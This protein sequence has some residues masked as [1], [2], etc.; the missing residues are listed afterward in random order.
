MTSNLYS[1]EKAIA[2]SHDYDKDIWDMVHDGK[3]VKA[4]YEALSQRELH[5]D[6]DEFEPLYD[7]TEGI[8]GY[9][10]WRSS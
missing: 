3:H 4:I 6:A 9:V 5:S 7:K 10:V 1:V 2:G 8:E